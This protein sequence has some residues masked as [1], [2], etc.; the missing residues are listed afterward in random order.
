MPRKE[1]RYSYGTPRQFH[2]GDALEDLE[3]RGLI[4][5][6]RLV[7]G[8]PAGTKQWE[9][10]RGHKRTAFWYVADGSSGQRYETFQVEQYILGRCLE[11]G[12]YW[13]PVPQPGGTAAAMA[14]RE[15]LVW[16]GIEGADVLSYADA[17][18]HLRWAGIYLP[19]RPEAGDDNPCP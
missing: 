2:I 16:K 5:G 7:R 18:E 12:I 11:N 14:V 6:W 1:G 19:T 9:I 4:S 17:V 3:A 15:Q 8:Y 10:A 13:A